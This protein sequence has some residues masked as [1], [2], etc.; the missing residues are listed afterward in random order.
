MSGGI[1]TYLTLDYNLQTENVNSSV[2]RVY[3]KYLLISSTQDDLDFLKELR[4][5]SLSEREN[6]KLD[7]LLETIQQY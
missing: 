1:R 6:N 2:I 4:N 7:E 3:L 5:L